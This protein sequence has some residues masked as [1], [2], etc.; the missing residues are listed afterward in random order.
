[1]MVIGA[2][3]DPDRG[4]KSTVNSRWRT[5][6]FVLCAMGA[7]ACQDAGPPVE[8]AP[9]YLPE[10]DP[11]CLSVQV[12]EGALS[13]TF[14]E[15][16]AGIGLAEGQIVAGRVEGGYLREVAALSLQGHEARLTTTPSSFA[17]AVD[18]G[19]LSEVWT[20]PDVGGDLDGL[21]VFD[22]YSN[23]A[24]LHV[25]LTAGSLQ[26]TPEVTLDVVVA[27]GSVVRLQYEVRGELSLEM[28]AD[29]SLAAP[30]SYTTEQVVAS[31]TSPFS[32]E[33]GSVPVEGELTAELI[34]GIEVTAI[35]GGSL[36]GAVM[37]T[38]DVAVG[39]VYEN[40]LWSET[41]DVDTTASSG[42]EPAWDADETLSTRVWLRPRFSLTLY[43]EAGP[44]AGVE[45]S[46]GGQLTGL[47]P[48]QWAID[49]GL[50]G[51][52]GL[53]VSVFD[54]G[55]DDFDFGSAEEPLVVAEADESWPT[56]TSV[57]A[58]ER[59]SC[60]LGT[61]GVVSCWGDDT[62]G[63][64]TPPAGVFSQLAV[65][66]HHACALDEAGAVTCWGRDT[67]VAP[68]PVAGVFEQLSA[69][70][71]F[72]C[73]LR[74]DASLR[75]WGANDAGQCLAP[76]GTFQRLGVGT[77]HACATDDLDQLF[78]W[79]LDDAGQS[80]PVPFVF[81]ELA[82]GR[83]FTCG[84]GITGHVTCWGCGLE[85]QGECDP[86]GGA[87]VQ[88]SAGLNHIC[89]VRADA[90]AKC[91]GC[92]DSGQSE[93]PAGAAFDQVSAGG[94]HSCG[95]LTHGAIECWG[96]DNYGQSTPP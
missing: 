93:P 82:A 91:W 25:E 29:V 76:T 55:L 6:A 44:S 32:S 88:L 37:V 51:Q 74:D 57:G 17:D 42:G 79:G 22:G 85:D 56:Y 71:N 86:P 4:E 69:G 59:F 94:H 7:W 18:E 77:H 3:P 41:W 92:M 95:L 5:W 9:L 49:V 52:A 12:E 96:N 27:E 48:P 28:T 47:T 39:A 54:P 89:A 81:D 2:V 46:L 80:S 45:S 64:A 62:H 21:V 26:F 16:A 19:S 58:G 30:F 13:L 72:T 20:A 15:A 66:S 10:E 53:P 83:H 75:C 31:R 78:C 70:S 23:V 33:L 84:L 63:Q 38:S 35:D 1:M 50:Q 14:S 60:G 11:R 36:I 87:F 67:A 34:A 8:S 43:G 68:T 65:G 90:S 24:D 73:G 40:G 61:D